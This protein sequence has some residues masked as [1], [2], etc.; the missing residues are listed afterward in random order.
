VLLP[1]PAA[2]VSSFSPAPAA[3][4]ADAGAGLADAV[5]AASAVCNHLLQAPILALTA[6]TLSSRRSMRYR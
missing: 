4:G 6:A 2:A 3:A 5:S 1:P